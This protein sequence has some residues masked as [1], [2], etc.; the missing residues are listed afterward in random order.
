MS[1][2]AAP[3]PAGTFVRV[4]LTGSFLAVALGFPAF[5]VASALSSGPLGAGALFKAIA[6]ALVGAAITTWT[7]RGLAGP[8][9]I[10]WVGLLAGVVPAALAAPRSRW[11][12]L[13]LAHLAAGGLLVL[14]GLRL[15]ALGAGAA[16]DTWVFFGLVTALVGLGLGLGGAVPR[17]WWAWRGGDVEPA[18]DGVARELP[19]FVC[20][21]L[22]GLS[23]ASGLAETLPTA[24]GF[25][26]TTPL[27][28]GHWEHGCAST[29][30][31]TQDICPQQ[32]RYSLRSRRG[33]SMQ[34]EWDFARNCAVTIAAD[35]AAQTFAERSWYRV[36]VAPEREVV[37]TIDG[38]SHEGCWY[39]LRARP[40][41]GGAQ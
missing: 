15:V 21:A 25:H 6:T 4:L 12:G 11:I 33:E 9:W 10:A 32:R 19:W 23:L 28:R 3:A 22:A 41:R 8:L 7:V 27:R 17:L 2:P 29:L 5:G 20:L 13:A 36:E 14:A 30:P 31:A 37:V 39:R 24:L 34:I 18:D 38:L 35:G 1:P 40:D 16:S 26:T